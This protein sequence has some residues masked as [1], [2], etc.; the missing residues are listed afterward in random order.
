MKHFIDSSNATVFLPDYLLEEVFSD[1]GLETSE[2]MQE[3][4]PNTLYMAQIMRIFPQE[5]TAK[6]KT[7][8]AFE[9]SFL[10]IEEER[11]SQ[12]DSKR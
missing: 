3:F 2:D 5:E 8:P 11:Q 9:E 6:Y 4:E 12:I 7:M 1:T 10:R